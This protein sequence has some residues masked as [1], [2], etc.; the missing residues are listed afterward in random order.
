LAAGRLEHARELFLDDEE[1]LVV[2][3]GV[4]HRLDVP[5]LTALLHPLAAR[6]RVAHG[7]NQPLAR[8]E[9]V[10]DALRRPRGV[11][12]AHDLQHR[13]ETRS[14]P[15]LR[16]VADEERPHAERVPFRADRDVGAGAERVP[17]GGEVG[18]EQRDVVRLG[19]WGHGV[20]ERTR[21]PVVGRRVEGR[22]GQW[23]TGLVVVHRL[24]R[25][26]LRPLREGPLDRQLPVGAPV[27]SVA[28][29]PFR[30][31]E[32]RAAEEAVDPGGVRAGPER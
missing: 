16:R 25:P 11:G 2:H 4:G 12:L 10:D 3:A 1:A 24:R 7:P 27:T 14:F 15:P 31:V 20:H 18:Q 32:R 17:H 21:Q 29:I 6:D 30:S 26:V 22:P 28:R 9:P 8:D 5:D 13:G 19:I 23:R